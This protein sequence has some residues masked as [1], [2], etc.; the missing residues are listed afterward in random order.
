MTACNWPVSDGR[1]C[2]R[3]GSPFF[4][5]LVL[6]RQHQGVFIE[7]L[8][9][10]V[11]EPEDRYDEWLR[12][13]AHEALAT[14]AHA[15]RA[16][17]EAARRAASLV[18]FVQRDG[19]VKIGYSSDLKQRMQQISTGSSLIEGMTVGPV[20]LLATIEDAGEET[21][22]WL[23]QRFGHL[24]IGGEWFLPDDDLRSFISGLKGCRAA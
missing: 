20:D 3:G 16:Q 23:H 7:D 4:S 1:R 21:E 6:C 2:R 24:R 15:E 8:R 17:R 5:A 12:D 19:F 13:T 9:S 14:V 10:A 22:R 18:Y 11:Q